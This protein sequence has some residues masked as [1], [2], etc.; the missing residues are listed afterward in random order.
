MQLPSILKPT[1]SFILPPLYQWP[2]LLK[3]VIL[4]VAT[5]LCFGIYILLGMGL[6][7]LLA[8]AISALAS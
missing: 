1:L 6:V 4:T 2:K 7:S 8:L 5:L 3:S